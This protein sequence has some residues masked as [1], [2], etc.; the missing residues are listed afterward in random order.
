MMVRMDP[1]ADPYFVWGCRYRWLK[2]MSLRCLTLRFQVEYQSERMPPC[3]H[4]RMQ[5]YH[6]VHSISRRHVGSSHLFKLM[7][8]AMLV[9]MQL[10]GDELVSALHAI[11]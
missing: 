7:T 8:S 4:A 6:V 3:I 2:H 11:D 5:E 10:V 1:T 9:R